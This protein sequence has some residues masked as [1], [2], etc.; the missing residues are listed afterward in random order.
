MDS[1]RNTR[2]RESGPSESTRSWTPLLSPP[3]RWRLSRIHPI[4]FMDRS[5]FN[6][7]MWQ[8][9]VGNFDAIA[10]EYVRMA[11]HNAFNSLYERPALRSLLPE[12]LDG[13]RFLDAACAGGTNTAWLIRRGAEVVG[14]DVSKQMLRIARERV[15]DS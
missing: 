3:M 12:N 6:K 13:K 7:R 9:P 4:A 8:G 15:G 14:L 1:Y 10:D 2:A 5:M 11:D